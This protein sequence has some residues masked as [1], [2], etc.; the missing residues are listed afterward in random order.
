MFVDPAQIAE[1]VKAHG[2][3]SRARLTVGRDGEADVMTLAVEVANPVAD[4]ADRVGGT[5]RDVTRLKGAV[6]IV[7]PGALPNDGK[8]ISDEREYG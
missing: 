7:A 3:I 2:E 6:E 1:I 8:V 5:L 4:L